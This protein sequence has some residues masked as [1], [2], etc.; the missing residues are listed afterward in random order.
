MFRVLLEIGVNLTPSA[1]FPPCAVKA[2]SR[3]HPR[4][5]ENNVKKTHTHGQQD[6]NLH[7]LN[8]RRYL[9]PQYQMSGCVVRRRDVIYIIWNYNNV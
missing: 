5:L 3:P 6:L 9:Q 7:H 2:G 8:Q 1:P 4:V